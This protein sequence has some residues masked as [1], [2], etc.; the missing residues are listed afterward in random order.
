MSEQPKKQTW[1]QRLGL[2][3]SALLVVF[4]IVGYVGKKYL[5]AKPWF[6]GMQIR[7]YE[8]QDKKSFPKPGQILFVGSSSIRY[9]KTLRRDMKPLP[10]IN[11]GFGGAHM[12]HVNYYAKRIVFPYKPKLIVLYAGENDISHGTSASQVLADLTTFVKLVKT[13]LPNVPIYYLSIKPSLLRWK[14]WKAMQAANQMLKVY[15]EKTQG[16]EWVD[17]A[18]G[19]LLSNGK[20]RKDIFVWDRL[21]MNDK[22]YIT[23][24]SILK[25]RLLQ[26][27][28]KLSSKPTTQRTK[29]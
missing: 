7:S 24:T 14:Q 13:K 17:V 26:A 5:A 15:V 1:W 2:A 19:M 21:H 6:W 28:K 23:W 8:K 11:R 9:W 3:L 12:S 4:L 25:P 18:S 27:W 29:P 22:G 20:V 16:I 10:V